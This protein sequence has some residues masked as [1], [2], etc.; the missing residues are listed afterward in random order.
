M[1]RVYEGLAVLVKYDPNGYFA[2][3]HDEIFAGGPEP[4]RIT[5]EDLA[6]LKKLGWSWD[7]S[8]PAWHKFV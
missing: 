4:I 1:K 2:A 3:E 7:E 6:T 8:L 5:E